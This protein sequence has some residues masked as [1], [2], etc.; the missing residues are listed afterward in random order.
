MESQELDNMVKEIKVLENSITKID[1]DLQ[2]SNSQMPSKKAY[3][4]L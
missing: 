1:D 4:I 3:R 2:L